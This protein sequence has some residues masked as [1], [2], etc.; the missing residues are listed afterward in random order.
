[1]V[2]TIWKLNTTK[3]VFNA[4]GTMSREDGAAARWAAMGDRT[5][6]VVYENGWVDVL[7]FDD[8]LTKVRAS[9]GKLSEHWDG[10][11]ATE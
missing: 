9:V 4:D 8:G 7:E 5:V 1:M 10:R 11:R 2:Q 6:V 3:A